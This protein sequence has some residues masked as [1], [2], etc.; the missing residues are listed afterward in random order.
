MLSALAAGPAADDAAAHVL[1]SIRLPRLLGV[2]LAGA[3]LATAGVVMQT[4]LRNPLASPL[5]L[6]VSQGAALGATCAIVLLGAGELHRFGPQAITVHEPYRVVLAALAGGLGT[7][8]LILALARL[9]A[10]RPESLVLAGV[11]LGAFSSAATMLV[12]YFAS[13]VQVAATLFWTFGDLGKAGWLEVSWMTALTL[14]LAALLTLAGWQFNALAWGE[15]S[16]RSLGVA[17]PRLRL[18]ALAAAA[19]LAAVATAFL[20]VIGFIGLIAPHLV[21]LLVGADHRALIPLSALAGAAVLLAAD[22]LGRLV[23]APVVLPVGA[24]TALLG[25]PLLLALL[26]RRAH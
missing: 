3:S 8:G 4:V 22:T 11:A 12:Q 26:L 6:G 15:D 2:L 25:A 23:M 1:W 5:T 7:A 21:R 10:M 13:E 18:W 16:A 14:P 19:V 24:V 9:R 20:G 17:V